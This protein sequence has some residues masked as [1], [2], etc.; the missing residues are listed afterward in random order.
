M[1]S[2]HPPLPV[3]LFVAML[4][5]EL[6]LFAVCAHELSAVYGQV[7]IESD[8]TPWDHT[9]YYLAEMGPGLQ[10][11]FLFFER[12]IDPAELA[13]I[14]RF[15]V[16]LEDRLRQTTV[17]RAA[18]RIN[19]DPGYVTEAKV[20]LSTTKDFPHRI[21]IG[22]DM[23]AE[24]TLHYDRNEGAFLP[25]EHTYPDFR[26]LRCRELFQQARDRLRASLGKK[27]GKQP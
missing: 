10:R 11:K 21:Y 2:L 15:T 4:A 24:S 20:V 26:T 8:V 14:K 27:I 13:T 5:S 6:T 23:Y 12:L 3:K 18:R 17:G 22:N 25:R 7:D 9:D 1:G 19:L 16:S